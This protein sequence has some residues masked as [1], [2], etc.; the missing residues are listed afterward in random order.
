[1]PVL[2]TS[3]AVNFK[4]ACLAGGGS[5]GI[6]SPR[7]TG[8]TAT[9]TLSTSPASRTLRKSEPPPNNQMSFPDFARRAT[10]VVTETPV[11][12]DPVAEVEVAVKA[13][14]NAK[15]KESRQK[16]ANL[17]EKALQKMKEHPDKAPES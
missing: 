12:Y 14:Q 7:S 9:P 15:D 2:D 11:K 6:P 4:F 16:A 1:M 13:W 10:A 3:W 8:L 5:S 17:L